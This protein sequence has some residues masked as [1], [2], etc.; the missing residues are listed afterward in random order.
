MKFKQRNGLKDPFEGI[1]LFSIPMENLFS[2]FNI[3]S[4]G[5]RGSV[6]FD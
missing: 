3:P 1:A 4:S 6:Q 2:P 5:K